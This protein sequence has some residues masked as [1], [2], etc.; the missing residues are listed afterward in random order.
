MP[1]ESRSMS[2]ARM[3]VRASRALARTDFPIEKAQR[4]AHLAFVA[5]LPLLSAPLLLYLSPLFA[6]Q[7]CPPL[8]AH[9]SGRATQD[10]VVV[11]P[12]HRRQ[13]DR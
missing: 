2:A 1:A 12:T 13:R 4:G 8:D 9:G 11:S 5:A 6:V 10:V 3:Q 7:C